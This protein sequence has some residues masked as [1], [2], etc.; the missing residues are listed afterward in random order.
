MGSPYT[1]GNINA[2]DYSAGTK[3][4]LLANGAI[5]GDGTYNLTFA[6]AAETVLIE[7]INGCYT[8]TAYYYGGTI[9]QNKVSV[10]VCSSAPLDAVVGIPVGT[11]SVSAAVT[12]FTHAELGLIE[13]KIRMGN[14]L[15]VALSDSSVIF[16][17]LLG[18][19]PINTIPAMP[20][21]I[22]TVSDA[23][24]YGAYIAGIGSWVYGVAAPA[25][26]GTIVPF[27]TGPLN[28]LAYAEAMRE[29]LS[30]DGVLNGVGR[31]ANGALISVKIFNI[32][33]STDVYR[34]GLAKYATIRLRGNFEAVVGATGQDYQRIIG[35]LPAMVSY[36]NSTSSLFDSTAI[37]ALDEGGPQISIG[38]PLPGGTLSGNSGID[39]LTHDITGITIGNE[40]LLI[41][42]I[43]Y[44]IF[45][46]PY[47]PNHF[48]NTT[49]FA[50]GVYILTIRATNNLGTVATKS[51][52]ATFSN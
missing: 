29:D 6:N 48:I 49:I 34:H 46:N 36:N 27:G 40:E 18:R 5:N 45:L 50:N 23:T 22:E 47:H 13:Y 37:T 33:L 8:E 52:S 32:P 10:N 9:P 19:N 42:G 12:P 17:Q 21:H 26:S 3:G 38:T 16:T 30:Q 41:D 43:Y 44:D 51:V 35:F 28:T 11:S 2:Y 15:S 39:G 20:Q 1:S 31:D 25:Q 24:I 7:A 14:A 4:A